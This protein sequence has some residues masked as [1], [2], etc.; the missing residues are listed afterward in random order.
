[1]SFPAKR[2]DIILFEPG[3][4][5]SHLPAHHYIQTAET[6]WKLWPRM[7]EQG[8]HILLTLM[9]RFHAAI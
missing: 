5:F 3:L 4:Y 2:G 7:L 6:V 9:E 8:E 1:M